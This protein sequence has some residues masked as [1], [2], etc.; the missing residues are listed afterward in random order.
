MLFWKNAICCNNFF[1]RNFGGGA[2]FRSFKSISN[3]LLNNTVDN[4]AAERRI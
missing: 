1:K 4:V 3:Y 2:L